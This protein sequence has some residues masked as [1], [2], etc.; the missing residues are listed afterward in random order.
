[1]TN[2]IASDQYI[3]IVLPGRMFKSTFQA[4]GLAPVVLSRTVAAAGTP[5]SALVPWN[6]CGAYMA[7][8]LGVATFS[9]LPY[10]AFNFASPLLAIAFVYAG[11][12]MPAEPPRSE[13]AA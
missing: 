4:R 1:M 8:T 7:A 2:V 3:A 11:L 5:T 6:S 10:A 9:Y 13:P 12:R